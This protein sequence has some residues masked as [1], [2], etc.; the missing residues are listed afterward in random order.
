[1]MKIVVFAAVASACIAAGVEYAAIFPRD[2]WSVLMTEGIAIP[3][4]LAVT[5]FPLVRQGPQK[6][7]LIRLLL[8]VSI[9]TAL[10]DGFDYHVRAIWVLTK[11][12]HFYKFDWIESLATVILP[13]PLAWLFWTCLPGKCPDCQRF[14][15]VRF[16]SRHFLS[17]LTSKPIYQCLRCEERYQKRD[18]TWEPQSKT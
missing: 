15:L 3:L 7:W 12:Q 6:D 14:S 1:M 13:V 5:A 17:G 10:Y 16:S 8:T 2:W 18:G 4:L 9:A 11:G